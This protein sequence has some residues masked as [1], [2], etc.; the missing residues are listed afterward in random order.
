MWRIVR[1]VLIIIAVF[2]FQFWGL[3]DAPRYASASTTADVTLKFTMITAGPPLPV[4]FTVTRIN[5]NLVRITWGLPAGAENITIRGKMGDYP[6]SPTDG[7]LVYAGNGTIAYDNGVN[8]DLLGARMQY[9]AYTQNGTGAWSWA[10]VKGTVEGIAVFMLGL[11]FLALGL[12]V[13]G[14]YLRRV[15]LVIG[16]AMAWLLIGVYGYVQAAGVMT[17]IYYWV[18]WFGIAMAIGIGVESML[19]RRPIRELREEDEDID[20]T[21]TLATPLKTEY[22]HPVDKMR[23]EHG[24]PP[25]SQRIRRRN[26]KEGGWG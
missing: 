7:Y 12:T 23:R 16:S 2:Q 17:S 6:S 13:G 15:V 10:P 3:L 11:C 21:K 8:L 14:F 24:L 26:D 20:H 18:F 19:V 4:G 25:S 22:E 5:D 9:V 1:L